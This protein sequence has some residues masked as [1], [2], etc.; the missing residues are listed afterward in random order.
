MRPKD[1]IIVLLIVVILCNT[2]EEKNKKKNHMCD[3]SLKRKSCTNKQPKY[4]LNFIQSPE[5]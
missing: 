4:H 3:T 1:N 2:E 5:G